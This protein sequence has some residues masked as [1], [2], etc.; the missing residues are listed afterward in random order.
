M[1][2]CLREGLV[3]VI[4]FLVCWASAVLF[5]FGAKIFEVYGI[6]MS[7]LTHFRP[8]WPFLLIAGAVVVIVAAVPK[9]VVD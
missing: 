3:A 8:L 2:I 1:E 9:R 6:L 5:F 7:M 4:L